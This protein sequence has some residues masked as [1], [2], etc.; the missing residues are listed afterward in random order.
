MA[1]W[2]HETGNSLSAITGNYPLPKN[3]Y[4]FPM[5]NGFDLDSGA[6]L[7]DCVF[8]GNVSPDGTLYIGGPIGRRN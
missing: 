4:D 8:G 3:P 2:V 5:K 1:I 7:E 6:A